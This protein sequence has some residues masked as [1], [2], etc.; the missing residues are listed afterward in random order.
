MNRAIF[1][2]RD[3]TINVDKGYLYK[4]ED[5]EFTYKAIESLN[6]MYN[7]GFKLIIVTNQSGIARGFYSEGDV[8]KLHNWLINILKQNNIELT[9]I[10]YC[11]H[12]VH[13]K[14]NKY[15]IKCD[16]RKPQL[17]LFYKAIREHNIDIDKSYVIGDKLKD[18]AICQYTKA[19]G[20]LI[21]D[22][23]EEKN[24]AYTVVKNLFELVNYIK[25]ND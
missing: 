11:P 12:Y 3:G 5:F 9:G 7:M 13:G 16:C 8:N 21:V 2:D 23:H 17:G 4:I 22:K 19:R 18:L 6:I 15:S 10:Y 20:V 14:I 1:L 25:I 24:H